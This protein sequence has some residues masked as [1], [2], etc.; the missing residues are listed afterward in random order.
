MTPS[1]CSLRAH[2]L[3]R[4][5]GDR[6]VELSL[7]PG[8]E[9][10]G[11]FHHRGSWRRAG[12]LD[13]LAPLRDPS[14]H[15]GPQERLQPAPVLGTGEGPPSHLAPI[16][17][18]TRGH[19]RSETLH[20]LL[21][22]RRVLV[23]L[24]DHL[25]GGQNGCSQTLERVQGGRLSGPQP[26]GQPDEGDAQA[27]SPSDGGDWSSEAGDS[28]ADASAAGS[29]ATSASGS[30]AASA[31]GSAVASASGSAGASASGSA[32]ASASGSAGASSVASAAGLAAAASSDANTSSESPSSG[33]LSRSP[34]SLSVGATIGR[35][36]S[37]CP[38]TRLMDS[39]R[40]RRSD[41][42]SRIL[43]LT[44]SPGWMISRGFSTW[45]W[46]SSEIWTRPSTPSRISTNAP[47]ATTLV[48]VPSS[49]S[50]ML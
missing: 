8:L 30:A 29:S 6:G 5:H 46:A 31:S 41:S 39:E 28:S 22:D 7:D 16:D 47:K 19:R 49:S 23:E 27:D 11:H 26:A 13:L 10:Q 38:S 12:L 3:L 18:P 44:W 1:S 34:A 33:M 37:S 20:S 32:A 50:P 9:Q 24:V 42:I 36:G 40:R 17:P 15:P 43:T 2:V 35:T 21:T 4:H 25:I 48:T 45:C 14:P